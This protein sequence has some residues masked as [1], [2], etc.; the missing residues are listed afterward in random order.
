M[1][2]LSLRQDGL[3]PD[4]IR[5]DGNTATPSSANQSTTIRRSASSK[6]ATEITHNEPR[7]MPR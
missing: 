6:I 7:S 5:Q 1:F 4:Q 2:G 3:W